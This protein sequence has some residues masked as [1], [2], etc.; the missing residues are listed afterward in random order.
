MSEKKK[1]TEE[2][3][4]PV[5][6]GVGCD[7]GTMNIIASRKEGEGI[8]TKRI[9]DCFL[10]MD[11]EAKSMLKLSGVSYIESDDRILIL[12]DPAIHTA[13]IFGKEVRRPI[14]NGLISPQEVDALSVLSILIENVVGK[15]KEKGEVCC[16]SVPAPPIDNPGQD[17][18]YHKAVFEKILS[19][20]GYD[21]IAS[22]EAM[23]IVFSECADTMFSGIGISYGS[24]MTNVAMS[25]NTMSAMEFSVQRGGDFL[26]Q[27]V[28]RAL[29]TTASRIC[30]I[31]EKGV[32]LADPS[33]G[34]E[35]TLREREA[36]A[37]YYRA[38]ISYSLDNIANEFKKIKDTVN[39]P[40]AIPIVV[41]GGTSLAPG[42]LNIFKEVFES[43]RRRFPIEI[44][45]I[46][47]A[48]DP[49]TAV[50]H[51]LLIQAIQEYQD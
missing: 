35:K 23:A 36:I 50:S 31:K 13:N 24:G 10:D 1:K 29:G 18:L 3:V 22:N 5:N 9:R 46:R 39:L 12:G 15:P 44:S 30:T 19:E 21:P 25:Y 45:E 40:T 33:E 20:L 2:V 48:T 7:I 6:L 27:S 28:A 26:D 16:F 38:L 37:T 17:V 41:G 8:Q 42:F 4:E 32:N 11:V 51:G 43:K 49:M 14:A 34:D 47:H